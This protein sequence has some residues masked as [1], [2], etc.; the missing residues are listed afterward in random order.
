MKRLFAFVLTACAA[1]LPIASSAASYFSITS[2]SPTAC[3]SIATN[4]GN[5]IGIWNAASTAQTVTI[6]IYDEGGATPSCSASDLV[7][8]GVL[9]ASQIITFPIQEPARNWLR[10]GL[11]YSLSAAA[12][13]NIVV[14]YQ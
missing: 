12:T 7:F 8:S 9:G 2:A 11:A 5:L 4:V 3:T 6:S 14:L 1:L 10:H 13:N